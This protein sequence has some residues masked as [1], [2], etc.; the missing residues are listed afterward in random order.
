MGAREAAQALE[1]IRA[2]RHQLHEMTKRLAWVKRQ[3]VT[4]RDGRA[5]ALRLEAANLYRDIKEA[6]ALIDRLQRRY[7]NGTE[8]RTHPSARH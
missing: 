6:Q 5:C 4:G 2:L 7:P 8:H 1:L 3:D